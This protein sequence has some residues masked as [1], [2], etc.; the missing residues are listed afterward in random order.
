M[1]LT[2]FRPTWAFNDLA[3]TSDG[4]P[5]FTEVSGF[6]FYRYDNATKRMVSCDPPGFEIDYSGLYELPRSGKDI[7]FTQWNADG[8]TKR[9][10]LKW[11]GR[12]FEAGR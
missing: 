2:E 3:S 5:L 1:L 6:D 11:N 9:K 12:R 4:K 10:V 8:T 7:I